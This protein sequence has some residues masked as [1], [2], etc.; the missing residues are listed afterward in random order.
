MKIS[1]I[2]AV[3][4]NGVIG[5]DNRLLWR[6]SKD[7]K[8]FKE[9]TSNR[10]ILM[11]RKTF[12]SLGRPLPNRINMVVSRNLDFE[13]ER[14]EVFD[15]LNAPLTFAKDAGEDELFVIGRRRNL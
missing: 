13:H 1:I 4:L 11:G 10:H 2:A 5:K 9:H 8:W 6:L 14:V 3:S 12:E 15:D 7:M